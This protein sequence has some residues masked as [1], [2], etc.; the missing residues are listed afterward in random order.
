MAD[1]ILDAGKSGATESKVFIEDNEII[2]T[3]TMPAA[4]VE[5]IINWNKRQAD[6]S[7]ERLKSG[8]A[9]VVG[10]RVPIVLMHKWRQE[11]KNGPKTW[12]VSWQKFLAGRLNSSDYEHLRFMK[13]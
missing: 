3:E 12:G 9:G 13:L 5:E 10:A 4:S 7:K 6:I 11:W 2:T 1:L 8:A